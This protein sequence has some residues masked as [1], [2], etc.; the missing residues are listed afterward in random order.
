VNAISRS[1]DL[2]LDL[3]NQSATTA[4][5]EGLAK[6][7][8]TGDVIAL[9]GGL[10]SGKTTLARAFIAALGIA[11]DVPSPTFSLVQI[12]ETRRGLVSHFDLYRLERPEDAEELGLDEALADGIVL[13]EWPERL[14]PLLPR[15]RLEVRLAIGATPEQR[16][17][18]LRGTGDWAARLSSLAHGPNPHG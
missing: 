7:A 2:H 8:R 15:E 13:I 3:P 10:G 5:A 4:L 6:L 1:I 11:E 12:Y 16:V 17:A 9:S 14:G 18:A